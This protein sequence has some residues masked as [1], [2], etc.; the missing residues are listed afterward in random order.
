MPAISPKKM[1]SLPLVVGAVV[2][3]GGI[4]MMKTAGASSAPSLADADKEINLPAVDVA[5][6]RAAESQ[7]IITAPGRLR[8]RQS[9]EI[10]GQVTGKVVDISDAFVLGGRL[11]K[12]DLLFRIDPT[13]FEA[14]ARAAKARVESA[15]ARLKF[16]ELTFKRRKG[17][18]GTAAVSAAAIDTAE[19]DL[20]AAKATLDEAKAQLR[21]A[22][23]NL[24]RTTIK[25]PFDAL[26]VE[27]NVAPDTFVTPGQVLATLLD[28]SVGELVAG[29]QPKDARII[30]P[31][32][33]SGA[34]IKARALPNP[35][36]VGAG[37]LIGRIDRF[38]PQVDQAAR[39][40]LV[41]AIFDNA[42][43]SANEGLIFADDF[44]TLEIAVTAPQGSYELPL[45]SV[46][47]DSFIWLVENG[48]LRRQ[49]V[50]VVGRSG[51][52][53]LA[54]AAA[55]LRGRDVLTTNLN[56]ESDGMRVKILSVA[57]TGR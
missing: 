16:A 9:T 53:L 57:E 46:R 54:K 19:A 3:F 43:S 28:S 34:V 21:Q 12:G 47:K 4:L 2:L 36:S 45:G 40:A 41:V 51:D 27:E 48:R 30:A 10:V 42:F 8:A 38:A 6:I 18:E 52:Y 23:E 25:A 49:A 15:V 14:N 50:Q 33:Q 35:G 32:L 29:L 13:D 7:Y 31:L 39:T 22:A 56:A 24:A 11:K 17:L 20:L 44:M 37:K 26:V 5:P 1:I 55:D